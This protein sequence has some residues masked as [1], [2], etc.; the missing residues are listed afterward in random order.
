MG[1]FEA[2]VV[3]VGVEAKGTDTTDVGTTGISETT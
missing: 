2:L 3:E 1:D